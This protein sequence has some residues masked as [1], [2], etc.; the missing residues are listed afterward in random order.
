MRVWLITVGEPLPFDPGDP[1]LLRTGL[2]SMD[3]ARRGHDVLWWTSDFDHALKKHRLG[4]DWAVRTDQNVRM[5]LLH[6]PAYSRAV[7][8]RRVVNHV[9]IARRFAR[10]CWR[11]PRPDVIL[12]SLP[13]LEL[14]QEAMR[15]ATTQ[16]IPIAIDVRDLWPDIFLD[17]V[18]AYV[19]VPA[20][21]LLAP[22]F[23]AARYVLSRATAVTGITSECVAWGLSHAGRPAGALDREFPLAYAPSPPSDAAI[24]MASEFWD[25]LGVRKDDGVF[26]ACY[27]GVIGRHAAIATVID[28]VGRLREQDREVQAIICGL[29]DE[30]DHC[31]VLARAHGGALLFPGRIGAAG[32]WTLMRRSHVGLAP[33]R[34]THNYMASVP[35]KAI[36]YMSAGLPVISSLKGVLERLLQAEDCGRTYESNDADGLARILA[37]TMENRL[38]NDRMASNSARIF[39]QRFRADRVYDRMCEFLVQLSAAQAPGDA[40]RREAA[41]R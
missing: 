15:Y 37:E 23:R 38:A 21:L 17:L 36:E 18:P 33:Y 41:L 27:F 28:A 8:L 20:R 22:M 4:R 26:R 31:R 12:C 19:R 7:S 13:T 29:G 25:S 5:R 2:L 14:C 16:R 40:K 39:E 32:I 1:R 35:T 30:L 6:A 24:A 11:E 34:S 10:L 3:L 9:G